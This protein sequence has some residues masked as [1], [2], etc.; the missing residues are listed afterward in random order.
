MT[1]IIIMA[2]ILSLQI[3]KQHVLTH[4]PEV[5]CAPLPLSPF[6]SSLPRVP[7]LSP[8]P[9]SPGLPQVSLLVS[10]AYG[11]RPSPTHSLG[12]H[13][14]TPLPQRLSVPTDCE[15]PWPA[16]MEGGEAEASAGGP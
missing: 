14:P 15:A 5:G 6:S 2:L 10:T 12:L 16:H 9:Q 4:P 7:L 13:Q 8:T 1:F 3:Q 11:P